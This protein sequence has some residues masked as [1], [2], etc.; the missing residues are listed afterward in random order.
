MLALTLSACGGKSD[1]ENNSSSSGEK[2]STSG[3]QTDKPKIAIILKTLSNPFWVTMKEGIEAKA[4]ELG[5]QVDIFAAQSEDDIQGQV[6]IIED[7]INKDYQGIGIAPLSPVSVIPAVVSANE[8]GIYVVNIDEK[9]DM[10][11]LKSAGGYVYAFVTTDNVQVGAN[12]ATAIVEALG[13]AGGE[14]AIIEGKAGNASGEARKSGATAVFNG[15]PGIKL[16]ASQPADW[17]RNKALDVASNLLQRYPNL[18]AIYCAND[19]MAL[20]ALQAVEN[21][22]KSDQVIV[23]GTDGAPEAIDSVNNGKLFATVAQ[24]SA[25]IGAQSLV[26]ILEAIEQKVELNKD[27]EPILETVD[28]YTIKK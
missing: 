25:K 9:I 16:V 17:D 22:G 14:V 12:G 7:V 26:K 1:G 28:S 27:L 8:K 15:S 19:T 3:E 20:G 23:V 10:D 18:K 6:K 2:G 13:E 11:E 4:E 21:A 24:D 5:V